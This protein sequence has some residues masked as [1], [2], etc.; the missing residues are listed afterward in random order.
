MSRV[1]AARPLQWIGDLSYSWYLW[2]WPLIVFAAAWYPAS[3]NAKTLAAIASIVPAWCSYRLIESPIRYRDSPSAGRTI[4]LAIACVALPL[5]ASFLLVRISNALSATDAANEFP[6]HADL[7]LGCDAPEPTADREL[8][9]CTWKIP[10]ARGQAFLVGDSNAGHFTEGFSAAAN[11]AGYDAVAATFSGCPFVDLEVTGPDTEPGS[12][13]RFVSETISDLI[14]RDP[15]LVV[16]ASASDLWIENSSDYS[17]RNPGDDTGL[18][19][20]AD[21]AAAWSEGLARVIEPLSDAGIPVLLVHPVPRLPLGW[22]PYEAPPLRLLGPPD[23]LASSSDR[24]K[25]LEFR[26]AALQ[27]EQA[28]A[29]D[30]ATTL[31]LFDQLCP[32]VRCES[33]GDDIWLYRDGGHISVEASERLAPL[34]ERAITTALG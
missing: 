2:H 32:Q 16:V 22:K 9:D 29:Q 18:A 1:L 13:N 33:R 7:T 31:D 21:R 17:M 20:S 11:A 30:I 23:K 19:S 25:A 5:L 27:A 3:G 14:E 6:F 24:A 8:Q 15:A 26:E 28:A 34:F 4:S 10:S 12:C